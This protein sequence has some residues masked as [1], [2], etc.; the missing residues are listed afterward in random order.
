MKKSG[1][2]STSYLQRNGRSIRAAGIILL[3]TC[4]VT[5]SFASGAG[6]KEDDSFFSNWLDNVTKTQEVQPHWEQLLAMSSPR[7][8]QAIRYNFGRQYYPNGSSLTNHG[9]G[10]GLEFIVGQN[11]E[12]QIG[13][14]AYISKESSKA[15]DS[16]W[17]DESLLVR[18]RF[19]SA[20]E[21]NGNYIASASLGLSL[22]TGSDQF[23]SHNIIL[24][25]TLAAGKGWGT[26]QNGIDIQGSV[27]ASVPDNN[28]AATGIQVSKVLALQGQVMQV[29]WP[30]I[31]ANHTHWYRGVYDGREQL[32]LTYGVVFGRFNIKDRRKV[33]FGIGYQEPRWANFSTFSRGWVSTLKLTF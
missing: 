25:P 28:L 32:V 4:M 15:T 27:S 11:T 29:F 17:A 14:P 9:M 5:T 10:K 19:I 7:L 2:E 18:Y 8:T 13:I 16:G 33:T 22:P 26:R 12:V 24:T 31:E 23:S 30:E 1:F 6:D 3:S 20:N 21:E